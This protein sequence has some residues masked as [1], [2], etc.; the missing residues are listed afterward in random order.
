VVVFAI[1]PQTIT[2][3][4]KTIAYPYWGMVLFFLA[5]VRSLTLIIIKIWTN[6]Q[7]LHPAI[8]VIA[9]FAFLA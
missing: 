3:Y 2:V 4:L 7:M 1:I 6:W 5:G 9:V 8:F